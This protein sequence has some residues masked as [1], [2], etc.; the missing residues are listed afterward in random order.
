MVAAVFPAAGQGKR[1]RA[2]MNKVF[3][4]LA[5]LPILVHTLRRFSQSTKI[6][7]LVVV[8]AAEEVEEIQSLLRRIP[9]L[10]PFQVVAG[11]TERQYSIA[12]GLAVL[13]EEA[14]IVLVHDAAR[15]LVTVQTIDGVVKAA[16]ETGGA[17]A[18]VPEKNTV[19]IISPD[20]IV[21]KTPPRE[22]LWEVQ[23]PQGFRRDLLLKAY[24]KAKEENFLGT[25]DSSLV[26]R[27]Q[28]PIKVVESDYRNIKVTTPED[29]IIAEALIRA[30]GEL[31]GAL[32][33]A[34]GY[35]KDWLKNKFH[36]K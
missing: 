10:K 23:T 26:E 12:N 33:E 4:E 19:K 3:L 20:G 2:G 11:S 13:P 7:Y 14:E 17:V 29:L 18:A 27:L 35:T 28:V 21:V 31:G 30:Q 6:D 36:R 16:Q 24:Q 5:G 15:P 32:R 1:M 22:T 9:H 34:A 8:V 25:D